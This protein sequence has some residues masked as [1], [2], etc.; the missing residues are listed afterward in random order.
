MKKIKIF[1][2]LKR[3]VFLYLPLL[4]FLVWALFPMYWMIVTSIKPDREL[5]TLQDPLIVK[6]PTI[7]QYKGLIQE[8]Q[9]P[10][11]FRNS[12]IISSVATLLSLTISCLAAYAISRLKFK[13]RWL[14]SRGVLFSYLV[15]RTILFL[16]LFAIV[17]SLRFTD[18]IH[19]LILVYLTFMVP[20]CT[21][22]LIGYFSAV[23]IEIEEC[24]ILDGCSR[25]RILFSV[26]L[27]IAA[28]GIVT[29]AL[30]S[31]TLS[32]NEFLYPLVINTMWQFQVVPVGVSRLMTGD[33]FEWGKIMATGVLFTLPL[34]FV[35]FPIQKY[36]AEGLTAGAVK[37]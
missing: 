23:P 36:I 31:F 22:L 8:T 17:Q 6:D 10:I 33:L 25:L 30:F 12:F 21:W 5:M 15:P 1:K 2:L 34:I 16:P 4:F 3:V 13:G 26:V 7:D 19:G 18:T 37:G 32:W 11:W 9:F 14:I 35:Y 28:P 27:P 24:A 20:F 29:S